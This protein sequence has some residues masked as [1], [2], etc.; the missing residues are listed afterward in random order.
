MTPLNTTEAADFL[1]KSQAAIRNLVMRR[2]IPHRKC[3][4]RL[5][6]IKEELEL[7]IRESPGVRIEDLEK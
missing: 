5:L 7:W 3:G 2:M 4:G 1:R 6:F